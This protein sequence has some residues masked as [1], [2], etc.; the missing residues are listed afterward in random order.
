MAIWTTDADPKVAEQ[1]INDAL[2]KIADWTARW[3]IKLAP[4]KSV[5][6]LFSKRP[7]HQRQNINLKL[8]GSEIKRVATHKFLGAKFDEK[9]N[10]KSH[11][12]EML[13]KAT[14][15][16]NAIKRIGAKAK[17]RNIE[18]LL[19]LHESVVG[20]IWKYAAIG[21]SNM[22]ENLWDSI[23]K[24]HARCIKS[25]AGVP[26]FASYATVTKLLGIKTAKEELLAFGRKRLLDIA[27]FSPFGPEIIQS[28]RMNVQGCYKSNTEILLTDAE[29]ISM[30]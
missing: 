5:F 18:W 29:I 25:Y 19:R 17:W 21:Y 23:N 13:S 10:W 30:S 24:V 27:A 22:S 16:I 28:R 14:P 20:S 9:L 15:R 12:T 8:L 4:E 11:V 1:R 7:T 6:M 2:K 3:R 26:N